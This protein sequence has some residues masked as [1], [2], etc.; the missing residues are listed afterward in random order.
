MQI[1]HQYRSRHALSGNI[2][3]DKIKLA[4]AL[5]E[6]DIIAAHDPRRLINEIDAPVFRKAV[7]PRQQPFLDLGGQHQVVLDRIDLLLRQVAQAEPYQRMGQQSLS[8]DRVMAL[9]AQT[10]RP[11][12]EP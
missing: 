3:E 1:R 11:L 12:I 2:A 4:V 9:L 7:S 5:D 10:I 8:L 6:I